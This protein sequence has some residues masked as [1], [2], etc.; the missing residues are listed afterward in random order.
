[1]E[2]YDILNIPH[3]SK[4]EE[5]KSAFRKLSLKFYSK[6]NNNSEKYNQIVNA[7]NNLTNH[8]L[9]NNILINKVIKNNTILNNKLVPYNNQS[10][11]NNIYTSLTLELNNIYNNTCQP[12]EIIRNI[13][14]NSYTIQE[15]ETMYIDIFA[16]IDSNEIIVIKNK[17]HIID[18]IQGDIK[19]KVIINNNTIFK[20]CGLELILNKNITLK[21]ALCGFTFDFIHLNNETYIIKNYNNIIYPNYHK[22][23]S[24]LGMK[25]NNNIGSLVVKFKIIFPKQL[26]VEQ[27]KILH[28]I[29]FYKIW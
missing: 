19:I 9:T 29:I 17:G 18:N 26:T 3:N 15:N 4:H 10:Y 8:T 14:K 27:K 16:G 23:L 24:D 22:I 1:M 20:R 12:I 2:N 5:I 21:E 6:E 28:N 25:R 13:T 11:E 7:Y